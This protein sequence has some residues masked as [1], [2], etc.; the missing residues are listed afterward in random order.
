MG[1]F[2]QV[3]LMIECESSEVAETIADDLEAKVKAFL[4]ETLKEKSFHLSFDDVGGDDTCI[5][6]NLSSGRVQNATW[7]GE[8]VRDYLLAKH[9]EDICSINGEVITP[10]S[11]LYW[12]KDDEE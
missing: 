1:V 5:T 6:V 11:Y 3:E 10:E 7:Q 4:N 12:D 8:M 9:K 2:G